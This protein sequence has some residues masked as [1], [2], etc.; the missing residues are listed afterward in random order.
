[1]PPTPGTPD[2]RPTPIDDPDAPGTLDPVQEPPRPLP[3]IVSIA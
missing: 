1:L 3:P 2:G